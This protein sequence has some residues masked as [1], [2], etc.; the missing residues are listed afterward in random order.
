MRIV[1]RLV[2]GFGFLVLVEVDLCELVGLFG[3]VEC[4]SDLVFLRVG[5]F[6]EVG[7]VS[8]IRVVSYE[9]SEKEYSL[10]VA[11]NSGD[12]KCSKQGESSSRTW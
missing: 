9:K 6:C 5:L 3:V 11:F 2:C 10:Y 1:A 8:C 12:L 7:G 4:G